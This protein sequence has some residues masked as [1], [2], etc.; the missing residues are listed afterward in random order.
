[1]DRVDDRAGA[2]T[3]TARTARNKGREAEN[4]LA[5]WLQFNGFPDA[6]R[7]A[8]KLE[9]RGDIAGVPGCAIQVKHYADPMRGLRE[10]QAGARKQAMGRRPVAVVRL[11]GVTDPAEWWAA[12][13]LTWDRSTKRFNLP[14]DA[15]FVGDRCNAHTIHRGIH[16]HGGVLR[17]GW[18]ITT[19]SRMFGA[20]P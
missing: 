10:A 3:I 15:R 6:E 17:G 5:T 2:V 8:S 12:T 4:R 13:Q 7:S 1:M 18:W 11:R 20:L 19:V 14:A 9:D 16:E